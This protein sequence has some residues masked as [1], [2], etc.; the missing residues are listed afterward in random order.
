MDLFRNITILSLEQATVLPHLTYRLAID[1]CRVI[2][3]EHPRISR[4][5]KDR[6]HGCSKIHKE[7]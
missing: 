6:N 2:R 3:L 1:G 4:I 7:Q 5:Q